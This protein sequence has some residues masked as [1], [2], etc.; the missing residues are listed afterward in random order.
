[1]SKAQAL[2]AGTYVKKPY[3]LEELGLGV[4]NELDRS[5]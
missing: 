2:G 4:R 5:A 3:V 1:V